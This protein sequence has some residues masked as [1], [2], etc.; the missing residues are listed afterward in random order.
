MQI[1]DPAV[2]LVQLGAHG[3]PYCGPLQMHP[4]LVDA[5]VGDDAAARIGGEASWVVA[6][7]DVP[8]VYREWIA[9]AEAEGRP[10]P[11]LPLTPPADDGIAAVRK[12]P[13]WRLARKAKAARGAE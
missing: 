7:A 1:D 11:V 9:A 6:G 5:D 8:E 13:S 4:G 2:P 10:V 3:S 12:P